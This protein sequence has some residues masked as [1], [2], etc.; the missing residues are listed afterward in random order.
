MKASFFTIQNIPAVLYC[1]KAD[2]VWLFVHGKRGNK[3]EGEGF[4][5]I[6]CRNG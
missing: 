3:E 4:A 5:E 6:L 2:K 1:E